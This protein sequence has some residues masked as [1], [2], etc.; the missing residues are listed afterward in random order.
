MANFEQLELQTREVDETTRAETQ[1]ASKLAVASP[2]AFA[3]QNETFEIM[4][5]GTRASLAVT[6]GVMPTDK[7]PKM[8]LHAGIILDR[9]TG[10]AQFSARGKNTAFCQ[11]HRYPG[12]FFF[13][14]MP[15]QANAID[16]LKQAYGS[17]TVNSEV[18]PVVTNSTV[19]LTDFIPKLNGILSQNYGGTGE[20]KKAML[21]GELK[22]LEGETN[23]LDSA[24]KCLR[25]MGVSEEEL[26]RAFKSMKEKIDASGEALRAEYQAQQPRARAVN[27]AARGGPECCEEPLD[28]DDWFDVLDPVEGPLAREGWATES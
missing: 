8:V 23:C 10:E 24:F 1:K 20:L 18:Q 6:W 14:A 21:S 7:G 4:K 2:M 16:R 15:S 3:F 17:Y 9:V 19:A 5:A 13:E 28:D 25:A 11:L 12:K 27:F 22:M 26:K